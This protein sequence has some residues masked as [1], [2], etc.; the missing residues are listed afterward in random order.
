MCNCC[1]RSCRTC[2]NTYG[3]IQHFIVFSVIIFMYDSVYTENVK[4]CPHYPRV[5]CIYCII[6]SYRVVRGVLLTQSMARDDD[7]I[8]HHPYLS[9]ESGCVQVRGCATSLLHCQEQCNTVNNPSVNPSRA[10]MIPLYA[11]DTKLN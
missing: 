2:W 3:Q 7:H 5:Y 10:L 1:K 9:A 11:V 4:P 6:R 8:D